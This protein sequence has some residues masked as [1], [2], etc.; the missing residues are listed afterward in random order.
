MGRLNAGLGSGVGV[1]AAVA[2]ASAATA[3]GEKA[4][5]SGDAEGVMN[6]LR[7]MSAITALGTMDFC[8][9]LRRSRA[10]LIICSL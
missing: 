8:N 10:L 4:A 5:S 9:S 1:G 2:V 7:H 6:A 3:V